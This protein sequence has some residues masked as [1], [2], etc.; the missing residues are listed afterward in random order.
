MMSNSHPVI[1]SLPL[2]AAIKWSNRE[3]L[4]FED[5]RWTHTE[6]SAEV[7]RL[8]AALI[9]AGAGPGENVAIWLPNRPEFI[10]L[11]F[12]IIRIGAVAV[13]LNTRYRLLDLAYAL[14]QS[15]AAILFTT[16]HAGP[17]PLGEM[18]S[19]VTQ[20]IDAGGGNV[21]SA[22]YPHLRKIVFLQGG[23]AI[24]GAQAWTDFLKGA[25]GVS[26]NQI[27]ERAASV[28]PESCAMIMYTSGTTGDAKG[29]MLNH[30]VVR[31]W[32]DRAAMMG[33][34][35]NDVQLNYLPLFHAYSLCYGVGQSMVSGAKHIL[36]EMF[37]PAEALNMVESAGI[38]ILHGFEIH[39]QLLLEQLDR[40][41]R[42]L[43]T[44][45]VAT[46]ATGLESAVAI[47]EATQ[48][49]IC[50]TLGCYGLTETWSGI[51]QSP[52]DA[53]LEQR[54]SGSGYPLPD[55]DI[56]IIDPETGLDVAEDQQG[57]ILVRGYSNMTGYYKMPA[58]TAEAIDA[59]GWLHTGDAGVLRADGH[60]RFL[61]R[62]KDMLKVGGENVSP[63]EIESLLQ[64]HPSV[65]QAAVV[66]FPDQRLMEVA[67][68]FIV[69]RP[70][71]EIQQ[72]D[73]IAFCRGKLASFKVPR[74]VIPVD[75]LPMTA[76][77]KVQKA[78]LRTQLMSSLNEQQK[79]PAKTV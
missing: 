36:T 29:V 55:I 13:P 63:A 71:A 56:R 11:F 58:E 8:S 74:L 59:D 21:S 7:D 27:S 26:A 62:Y 4:V 53:T 16:E 2:E 23:G 78:V 47:A 57:E 19:E 67:A 46:F 14:R 24:A 15:D 18:I 65:L 52:L 49:R 44:L 68:A 31:L 42:N 6:V 64:Q 22:S 3:A 77:G 66:G 79:A 40:S 70:E 12:A 60:L 32:K 34:T 75:S 45:R 41:P 51:T 25:E 39:F 28:D 20:P 17:V 9:A 33:M 61:G 76:S 43:S 50:P 48:T 30:S 38:T 37:D 1:G 10:F 73:I 35:R 69:S 54:C 5:Q 72:D